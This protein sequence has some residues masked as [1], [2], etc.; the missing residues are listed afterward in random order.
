MSLPVLA[1]AFVEMGDGG[2]HDPQIRFEADNDSCRWNAFPVCISVQDLPG[3]SPFPIGTSSQKASFTTTPGGGGTIPDDADWPHIWIGDYLEAI[4]A[5]FR[6]QYHY[7]FFATAAG[8]SVGSVAVRSIGVGSCTGSGS[9]G[10]ILGA[11]DSGTLGG[12]STSECGDCSSGLDPSEISMIFTNFNPV[13]GAVTI[14]EGF[15]ELAWVKVA[16]SLLYAPNQHYNI[17]WHPPCGDPSDGLFITLPTDTC[18]NLSKTYTQIATD[19]N[20]LGL[21]LTATIL[22]GHGGDIAKPD[23]SC[24]GYP[25][26]CDMTGAECSGAADN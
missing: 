24:T 18:G 7:R 11:F 12:L 9:P 17:E 1:Q 6:L 13:S 25:Y 26:C 3:Y 23:P 5:G 4:D 20:N 15:L 10:A 2:A 16:A 19:V 22:G 14:T 8:T 21:G